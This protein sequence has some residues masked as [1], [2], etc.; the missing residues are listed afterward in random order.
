ML[1]LQK[2]QNLMREVF[3][4]LSHTLKIIDMVPRDD[5]ELLSKDK[6]FSIPNVIEDARMLEW[7]GV[8]FGEEKTYIL[9][10]ALK[11]SLIKH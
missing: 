5:K 2:C 1:Y 10:K 4:L 7:A 3:N 9:S 11:V 8:S 6:T